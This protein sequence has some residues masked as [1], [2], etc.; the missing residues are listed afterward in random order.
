[1]KEYSWQPVVAIAFLALSAFSSCGGGG[2][3]G[4]SGDTAL[5]NLASAPVN[6]VSPEDGAPVTC[7]SVE[8]TLRNG[9]PAKYKAGTYQITLYDDK[10]GLTTLAVSDALAE[11][12]NGVVRWIPALKLAENRAYWW[13]WTARYDKGEVASPQGVFY[14]T[15]K[16]ALKAIAPRHTGWMDANFAAQPTLALLNAYTGDGVSVSYDFELYAD[17]SLLSMISS[18]SW[19]PQQDSRY[20]AWY[21]A[22]MSAMPPLNVGSTYYWRARA[23]LNGL[24]TGWVGPYSFT[25]QNP[26]A[27][28][29]GRYASYGIDWSSPRQC[30]ALL[31]TDPTAALGPPDAAMNPWRN[32][33][34]LDDGG[35]VVLEMGA[36]VIDQPGPD[37]RVYQYISTEPAE[38]LVGPT[39]VGP[40]YSL[41]ATWCGDWCDFDLAYAGV[42]YA[43]YIKI[44]DLASPGETC[45]ETSGFDVDAVVWLHPT[46]DTGACGA[47]GG[48]AISPNTDANTTSVTA[49]PITHSA[50]EWIKGVWNLVEIGMGSDYTG[51]NMTFTITDTG[52][53]Y[54]YPGCHVK[55]RLSMNPITP[56]GAV[57]VY[58]LIMDSV[59]CTQEWDIKTMAGAID[60]GYIWA[61]AG[62]QIFYRSSFINGIDF[63]V[64]LR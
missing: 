50:P 52:F 46:S 37:I 30:S 47:F 16:D 36:T 32:F 58:A 17:E 64:Y 55:G 12:S 25:V 53:E 40:W 60:T 24:S 8:F 62:G 61:E 48:T 10:A 15:K 13:K 19:L 41:G 49:A 59:E 42:S 3:A 1:M 43:R 45:H 29:G 2:G 22:V 51:Y 18:I 23:T 9:S 33:I 6:Y 56:M 39:E 20:T 21:P 34:S 4:I 14:V 7:C 44:R 38:V 28:P 57:D 27:I 5:P 11:D 54:S 31:L 26:C 63:W 35:S